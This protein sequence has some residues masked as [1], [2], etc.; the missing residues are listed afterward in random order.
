MTHVCSKSSQALSYPINKFQEE[1]STK[2]KNQEFE[3]LVLL[4]SKAEQD[5]SV[6]ETETETLREEI[7]SLKTNLKSRVSDSWSKGIKNCV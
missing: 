7:E 3:D 1:A 5:K 6:Q 4:M 2:N